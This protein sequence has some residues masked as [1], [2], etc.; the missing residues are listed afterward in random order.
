MTH[1]DDD[2]PRD[3][4]RSPTRPLP[5]GV[6]ATTY[7]LRRSIVLAVALV[8][9]AGVVWLVVDR[10]PDDEE[11]SAAEPPPATPTEQLELHVWTPYWALEHSTPQLELRAENF[12]EISP[13]WFQASGVQK[14]ERDPHA[15]PQ[16]ARRFLNQ[17]REM[18][19]PLVP[20]ILDALDAGEMAE[21]LSDPQ[22]RTQHVNTIVRFA[23][24]GDYDGIDIDYEQFA[25]ADGRDSWEETQP[26]WVAFIEELSGK[27]HSDGRT[28]TVS[29]PP[30]FDEECAE[31]NNHLVFIDYWVY[32]YEEIAPLV[33]SIRV[34]AYD[35]STQDAGPIAP[36]DWVRC[37]VEGTSAAAGDPSKL[38]LGIPV[39]GYNWP[40][41]VDGNC[42]DNAPNRTSVSLRSLTDLVA[43]RN[44]T[45]EWDPELA[46]YSFQ[47]RLQVEGE[48]GD[49]RTCVQTREVHYVDSQGAA[50]RMEIAKEAGFRGMSLWAFGYEDGSVWNRVT[51]NLA[52]RDEDDT[53]APT[54]S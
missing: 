19:I 2:A 46:E 27:L 24:R 13:F 17:A 20:S 36:L 38:I 23:R 1:T 49:T 47:Y 11:P 25:F 14:I 42:P 12:T 30:V 21:I 5:R 8:L 34:M 35:Y 7:R 16:R 32:A 15:S 50:M 6:N 28:L 54:T 39:S 44:A 33:D 52:I 40:V 9:V 48:D 43:R 45:P 22:T 4:T 3:A 29:I 37:A 41:A 51:P 10:G 31:E 26:N 18:G 53:P